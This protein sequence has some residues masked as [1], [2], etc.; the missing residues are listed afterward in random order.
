M[1][2]K[3]AILG[4]GITGLTTAFYLKKNNPAFTVFEK[5]NRAGGV[6][7]SVS[8]DGFVWETGPN[9]GVIGKPEV[10][11]L[12]EDLGAQYIYEVAPSLAGNLYIWK[13]VKLHALPSGI[14]SGLT[15]PLFSLR[16]KLGMPFEPFRP[17][18]TDPEENLTSFVRRRLGKSILDYAVDP[19]VSGVYAGNP[20]Q[21]ITRHALPKLYAL[22]QN[23]GGFIRGSIAKHREYIKNPP[24]TFTKDVFSAEGG[25]QKLIDALTQKIGNENILTSCKNVKLETLP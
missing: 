22:E 14:I 7:R 25:F 2:E 16:D 21:L 24:P 3:I 13:K 6:I 9:T 17:R 20:A 12:V 10:A 18:G 8:R 15:T 11:E 5:E 23:Y 1:S 19:F 4:A